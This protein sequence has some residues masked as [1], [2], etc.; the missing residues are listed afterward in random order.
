M[1]Q[2]PTRAPPMKRM[3]SVW[4][5]VGV[6]VFRGG[7]CVGSEQH[8][9][10]GEGGQLCRRHRSSIQ[11]RLPTRQ[12]QR[13]RSS[14]HV[15]IP[16]QMSKTQRCRR[17][18]AHLVH[19]RPLPPAWRQ[20]QAV[21]LQPRS[22]AILVLQLKLVESYRLMAEQARMTRTHTHFRHRRLWRSTR[23]AARLQAAPGRPQAAR[24]RAQTAPQQGSSDCTATR[25]KSAAE[26]VVM[27]GVYTGAE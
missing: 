6:H 21:E 26:L 10:A 22:A 20:G 15:L 16:R 4:A 3:L 8:R 17:Q 14:Q 2:N 23:K 27:S 13:V 18:T 19:H 11:T 5:S 7:A 25:V 1:S 24:A 9:R 12:L